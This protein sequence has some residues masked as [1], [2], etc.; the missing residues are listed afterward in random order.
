MPIDFTASGSSYA[1]QALLPEGVR[2]ELAPMA[3]FEADVI[4]RLLKVFAGYGYDRV[5]P[6]L[7]EYEDSLLSGVGAA[8]SNQ[9]FRLMD[10]ATQRTM[11]IRADMTQQVARIASTRLQNEARP[12]RLSYAGQ[13]LRTKGSEIRPSREFWQAGVEFFGADSIAAEAEVILLAIESL[14]V[15][16]V[17]DITL[18]LTIAPLV[19]KLALQLGLDA[20][21]TELVRIALDSKDIA[22]LSM[23]PDDIREIFENILSSAD[24]ASSAVS[25]LNAMNLSGEAGDLID[26]LASLV[27]VLESSNSELS[28]TVD[29]G[30]SRGFE[31]KSGIGF[32][33]FSRGVRGELGRGGRYNSEFFDGSSENATGFSVYLDSILRALPAPKKAEKLFLLTNIEVSLAQSFRKKGWRTVQGLTDTTHPIDEALRLNC[34]H[35][36]DGLNIIKCE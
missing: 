16:G 30:E 2:D 22:A 19:P 17:K 20:K 3:D 24:E 18:D 12:L 5:S 9:M 11:A 23:L 6:P 33:V 26:H 28:I 7:V 4:S 35:Y 10:A 25:K 13:V 32:A 34:S 14:E 29:P 1:K 21:K 15:V 27:T 36:Y 31:Y 8:K